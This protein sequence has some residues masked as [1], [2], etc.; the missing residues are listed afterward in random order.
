MHIV[1]HSLL[2]KKSCCGKEHAHGKAKNI[3]VELLTIKAYTC[4]TTTQLKTQSSV[5]TPEPLLNIRSLPPC[6]GN[7]YLDFCDSPSL[8]FLHSFASSELY[9]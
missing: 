1:L 8:A 7:R 6:R 5:N 3:Y 4:V 9:L 2:W